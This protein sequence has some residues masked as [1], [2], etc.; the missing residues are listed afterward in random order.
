MG[1][2]QNYTLLMWVD[3]TFF[4]VSKMMNLI[5]IHLITVTVYLFTQCTFGHCQVQP[6]YWCFVMS[7]RSD[8]ND[9]YNK[10]AHTAMVTRKCQAVS[11]SGTC[12]IL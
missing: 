4:M 11:L 1:S 5:V 10:E 9:A 3:E 6:V 7:Y 12:V 2:L 8:S